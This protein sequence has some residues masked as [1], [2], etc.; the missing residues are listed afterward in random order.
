MKRF[1]GFM[2]VFALI[3]G[4]GKQ[5]ESVQEKEAPQS[6]TVSSVDLSNYQPL[7]QH[8]F[9]L[10]N[11]LVEGNQQKATDALN[12]F[13]KA[14]MESG[15]SSEQAQKLMDEGKKLA[16]ATDIAQMRKGFN[17]FSLIMAEF[18][19]SEKPGGTVYVQFCPMAMN[20][21]GGY[22]LSPSEEIENPYL[23][24]QMLH[25][26]EVKETIAAN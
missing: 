8:Y 11:A 18:A 24:E 1:I 10:K 20:N 26:G 4:C 15:L 16:E 23:G 25:C 5:K 9:Q 14:L 13:S 19:K 7:F 22:W 17:S 21:S 3:S 12:A 2:L 6:E